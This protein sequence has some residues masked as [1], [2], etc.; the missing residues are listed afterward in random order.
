MG[1]RVVVTGLGAVTPI[2]NTVPDFWA[3]IRAGKSGVG[4]ITRFDASPHQSRV[5]AEIKDFNP[6]LYIDKRDI[7][8]MDTF[9]Q[10]AVCASVEAMAD[11]GF[12]ETTEPVDGGHAV[13]GLD[14]RRLAVMLGVGIGGFE[15]L[16]ESYRILFDKG[17]GRVPPMT[18]PKLI[19]NIGPGNVSIALNAQGACYSICTACASGTDAIGN[20]MR[21]I[22]EGHADVVIAGGAEACITEMGIAGFDVIQALS[23][24]YNDRPAAAS[25]PFD[26]DRDGFVMG[27]GA[28][29]MVLESLTHAQKRNARIYCEV[30]GSGMT[31]DADHLTAPH[32]E[33]RG[34][35]AAMRMALADAALS[36][37]DIQYINAHGTS[38]PINDPTETRAIKEVFGE[39]AYALRVSST[40]SM[41]GHCIGA[42][43][44]IEAV[45]CALALRDQYFPATIN[46]DNP[47]PA[48]DLDYVPHTGM[49][50]TIHAVVS[51]SLGFGGHNGVLVFKKIP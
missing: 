35:I 23:R 20:A 21:W 9:S 16:E 28:G 8:K 36:P 25:R 3:S 32:P 15:T 24:A 41:T 13:A 38:T 22:R 12:L 19:S 48:C 31:C 5:A 30:A 51:N 42:A 43:G 34:A 17:P 10:Y 39:H 44:G 33:G 47:D 26:R 11:A 14:P 6:R 4:P 37:E 29:I 7:R 46:L 50:G 2:G 40:K 18:I 1:E 27:E 49:E 45:A